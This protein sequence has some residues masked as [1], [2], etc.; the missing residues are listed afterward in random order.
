[1]SKYL[2]VKDNALINASYNLELVEQRLILLAAAIAKQQQ[3]PITANDKVVIH[4][5]DYAK[6]FGKSSSGSLYQ[7]LKN[8]CDTLFERQFSYKEI[9]EK[10]IKHVKSR[11]VSKVA[12]IPENAKIEL[13]FTAD[14]VPLIS[15][16]E[17]HF[18]SYELEQ[19]AGL[20]SKY[21]VRLYE[22]IIAWRSKGSTPMLTLD[23]LRQRLGV[24]DYEYREIKN[25]KARVIDLSV[26]QINQK[27]DITVSYKQHKEGRKIVG[28]TFEFEQ[29]KELQAIEKRDSKTI[30]ILTTY[31][32]L[33]LARIVQSRQ[34]VLDYNHLISSYNPANSNKI[35]WTEYFVDELK[36]NPQKFYWRDWSEYLNG[37]MHVF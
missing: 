29:K 8:A 3:K 7:N 20:S 30:D 17:K 4:V 31:T 25:L 11:W 32:D 35:L 6:E 13:F 10:E 34:F 9:K 2:V 12:Y 36:A 33:Q 18:T 24:L 23:E 27:T 5:A 1:M 19:V 26:K 14:V 37:E 21:A 16:L 22:I 15:M 28:F